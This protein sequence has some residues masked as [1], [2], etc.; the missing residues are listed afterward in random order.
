MSTALY[1]R[2]STTDQTVEPQLIELRRCA[3]ER[4]LT[5]TH[6]ITD[7]I[8]GGA[9]RRPGLDRLMELVRTRGIDTLLVV[10]LDRLARSLSSFCRLV[11]EMKKSGV[12][13]IIPGQ[14]IDTSRSNP[15]ADMQLAILAAVAQFEKSLISERTKA[16]LVAA[17]ARG[18]VLGRPSAILPPQIART[19]IVLL[20]RTNGR[21]GGFAGL[22]HLLGGVSPATAWRQNMAIPL[23][24]SV[25][26]VD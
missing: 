26:E 9:D 4:G 14:G 5:V 6:E 12:A 21:P 7:T 1:C 11:D 23:V 15:C 8:S 22:G 13:L 10:K 18:K 24:E 20:W 16:G 3:A 2:V 17:R 25:M 19:S